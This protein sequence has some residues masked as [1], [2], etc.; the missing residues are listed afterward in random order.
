MQVWLGNYV[1]PNDDTSYTRQ[2][3]ELTTAIQA[4]G[5]D[6]VSG[7]TGNNYCCSDLT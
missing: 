1:V 4:F 6:H 3:D 5:V 2:R 7:I